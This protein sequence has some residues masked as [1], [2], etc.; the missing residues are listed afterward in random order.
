MV[1]SYVLFTPR[2]FRNGGMAASVATMLVTS[3]VSTDNILMLLRAADAAGVHTFGAVGNAAFGQAGQAAVDISLVLSQLGYCVTYYVF[4]SGNLPGLF[5]V[6]EGSLAARLLTRNAVI[7]FQVAL[8]I[9]LSWIRRRLKYMA[10]GM[11]MANLCMVVGLTL[12]IYVCI[13]TLAGDGPMPIRQFNPQ[14]FIL[15]TGA[16]VTCFEG[17]GLVLPIREGVT[18]EA[19]RSFAPMIVMTM[20]AITLLYGGFA[21]LGYA[22]YGDTIES[23]ITESMP[24]DDPV[25]NAAIVAYCLCI[26]LTF[27]LQLFPAAKT[28]ERYYFPS[29]AGKNSSTSKWKK[30][31]LRASLVCLTALVALKAGEKFDH[32]AGI[33]GGV[34]AVPLALVYPVM[35]HLKLCGGEVSRLGWVYECC[36]GA[37]GV[38]GAVVVTITSIVTWQ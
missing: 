8:F 13:D 6:A 22:T 10:V 1:G 23:F 18:A 37:V 26:T 2:M 32:F 29:G 35:F 5:P 27:P 19:R 20:A 21:A 31:A 3:V 30:N 38:V 16:V 11:L 24:A 15:F 17:I 12:I 25:A 14:S 4:V 7:L 28:I 33:L 9:P 34:C 36:V